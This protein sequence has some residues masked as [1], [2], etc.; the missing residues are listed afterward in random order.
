[1]LRLLFLTL[2]L[3]FSSVLLASPSQTDSL[4]QELAASHGVR[5]VDLL[6]QLSEKY[7]VK[8]PAEALTY[9]QQAL[10]LA[11]KLRYEAGIAEALGN[12]GEYYLNNGNYDEALRYFRSALAMGKTINKKPVIAV[13]LSKIGVVYYFLGEYKEALEYSH[14]ALPMH[15]EHN[16]LQELADNLS[17][18]SYIYNARGN[19]QKALDYSLQALRVRQQLRDYNEIAK[20]LNSIGDFYLK[21]NNLSK[22]LENYRQSLATSRKV[23]NKRGIAFSMNNIGTVYMRQG[24]PGHALRYYQT[25]L[26]IHR[27]LDNQFQVAVSLNNLGN[28]YLSLDRYEQARRNFES[29]LGLFQK[30]RNKQHSATV[31]S[32]IGKSYLEQQ[33]TGKALKYHMQALELAKAT[34]SQPLLRDMYKAVADIY[35]AMNQSQE[36]MKYYRYYEALHNALELEQNKIKIAEMQA[37]FEEE[38]SRKELEEIKADRKIQVMELDRQKTIRNFLL[39]CIALSV[40]FSAVLFSFYRLKNR[41]NEQ[42]KEQHAIIS[43]QNEEL[44]QINTRLNTLNEKLVSSE[45]ELRK[46]NETKDKFFSIIA[47]DL[48]SP[49]A[50]FT[51][52][53]SVLSGKDHAFTTEQITEIAIGTEKSLRNLSALLNNLLQWSQS[54]MGHI[55]YDPEAVW[56]YEAA[57][58]TISLLS[59]EARNKDIHIQATV[60]H[61]VFAY[62]DRNMLSFVLRNLLSNAIK[63]TPQDGRICIE[64]TVQAEGMLQVVVADSGVGISPENILKLFGLASSFTTPGTADE[65]GTGLGLVLCKEFVEKNK[66]RIWV[67]SKVNEGSRFHFTIPKYGS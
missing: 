21:Q 22:S 26:H 38:K 61:D 41:S 64:C 43:H 11:T 10:Q 29:A 65:R 34:D 59:D 24:E 62:A 39:V 58:Q 42:L 46:S 4:K 15:R 18:I 32:Q 52:F 60:G 35:L 23:D 47:H 36:F 6:N 56:M 20:S 3:F 53:L 37:A 7:R 31:L 67:E 50:T 63:F 66:G 16:Q 30:L 19:V 33:Q 48:R 5:K 28:A 44:S 8:V 45:A 27:Q 1:M 17:V 54:Q 49:L 51:A 9:G 25:A 2:A 14:Q 57:Q 12:V 40:A 13:F 55:R